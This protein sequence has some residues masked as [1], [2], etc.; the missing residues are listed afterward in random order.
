MN[1]LSQTTK[2]PCKSISLSAKLC[3]TGSKLAK[4]SGTVCSE[5]YALRGFYNMPSV[6]KSM[7]KRLSFMS[8]NDFVST[9]ITLLRNEKHFRWFDSGDIQNEIM[10][11][12]IIDVVEQTQW[13]EHWI[14]TKEYK[15]WRNIL[16]TRIL[17][18]NACL[19]ASTPMDNTK[20]IPNWNQTSTTFTSKD[21]PAYTGVECKA[22]LNKKYKCEECRDCWDNNIT[23]IAYPKR[24]KKG[25]SN[26]K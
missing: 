18:R 8:G 2:M 26:G 3:N 17:P 15:W 19:R 6:K 5:C 24:S 1:L 22:H 12:H 14:P 21:S 7:D 20:P 4:I 9:M 25:K 13:C 11:H 16:L 23:N 10:G